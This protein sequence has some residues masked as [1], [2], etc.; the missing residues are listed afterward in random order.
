MPL[1]EFLR[2][3]LDSGQPQGGYSTYHGAQRVQQDLP[4]M[5]KPVRPNPGGLTA[6][7]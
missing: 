4:P 2:R 1:N 3:S 6:T 5:A 7:G